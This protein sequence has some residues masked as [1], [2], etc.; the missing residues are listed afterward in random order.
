M[1]LKEEFVALVRQTGG[2]K[3]ELCR[4]FGMSPQTGYKW[5]KRYEVQDH[6]GLQEESRQSI[7]SPKLTQEAKLRQDQPSFERAYCSQHRHLR[8]T[9][10]RTDPASR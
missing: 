1:S 5:L 8:F 6:Q 3:R 9:S 2:N 4:R 7:T 10:P